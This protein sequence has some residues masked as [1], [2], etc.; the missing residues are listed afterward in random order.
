VNAVALQQSLKRLAQYID[1]RDKALLDSPPLHIAV[2]A[3][4]NPQGEILISLRP[5][6][7]H[8]GG[9]WEFPGGKVEPGETVKQAL[10]R[11][12]EEEL[13]VTPLSARPF[14]QTTY[15]YADRKVFLDVWRLDDWRGEPAAR[16]GQ[17][18][19]WVKPETLGSFD[20]LPADGPIVTATQLPALYLITPET[21]D[22]AE[23][24]LTRLEKCLAAGAQLVQFRVKQP[25]G[26][27]GLDLARRVAR[28]CEA[29]QARLL[30]N[31]TASQVVSVGAHGL[32][33]NRLRLLQLSERP[34]S[35]GLLLGASCHNA[36]ELEHAQRLGVDFAAVSPVLKTASHPEAKPLGWIGFRRLATRANIPIYAL[37]GLDPR[38]LN[39]AWKAGGQGLAMIRGVWDAADP[40]AAVARC[41][42]S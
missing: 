23:T 4:W 14:F 32:H 11:E 31:G 22:D 9:L 25:A 36:S 5:P 19:R 41:L 3:L 42:A 17:E 34:L 40:A 1:A 29:Y 16:E 28:I 2:A 26:A 35:Q 24:F 20:F 18:L 12:L 6:H 7:W 33:L 10:A 30:L 13:G 21:I 8:Q 15:A 39:L 37:G 38:H 27:A